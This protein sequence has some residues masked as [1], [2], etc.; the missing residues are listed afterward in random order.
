[1]TN[2]AKLSTSA[3]KGFA[4]TFANGNTVSVQWGP[5]NYCE[6]RYKASVTAPMI[7]AVWSSKTA[8]VAAWNSE[9][10]MHVFQD[11]GQVDGWLTPDEVSEFILFV[12]TN[13]LT[14]TLPLSEEEE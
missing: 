6:A 3:N 12:A 10:D 8:E 2:D 4:I 1:M 11:G 7:R 13:E 14:T 5:T 9:G